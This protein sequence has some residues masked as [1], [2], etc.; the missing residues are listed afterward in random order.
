[1]RSR[2]QKSN[3]L[4]SLSHWYIHVSLEKIH[5][6]VQEISYIQ[7]YDLEN[8]V[9]VTKDIINSLDCPKGIAVLNCWES[10]HRF[11]RY[12]NF[13]DIFT[14]FSPPV[15]LKIRSS[16]QKSNQLLSLC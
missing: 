13:S 2:S 10:S 4:L 8:K 6:L 5:L 15:I 11:K 3:Q 1:M 9:K 16:S 12:I 14:Y 7:D